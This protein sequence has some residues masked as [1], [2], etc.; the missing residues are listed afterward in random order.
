MKKGEAPPQQQGQVQL[1]HRDGK[2]RLKQSPI[3]KNGQ[4]AP[5][6]AFPW[7]L[8]PP[9]P[10]KA[11]HHRVRRSAPRHAIA[12][13][14]SVGLAHAENSKAVNP[15]RLRAKG[16]SNQG[17]KQAARAPLSKVIII[18]TIIIIFFL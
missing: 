7:G 8:R 16:E 6:G 9:Q 2:A 13:A 5:K 1:S 10:P 4:S 3:Y 12:G 11:M 17:A 14:S 18:I 15:S